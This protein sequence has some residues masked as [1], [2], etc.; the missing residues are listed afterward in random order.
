[1]R[2]LPLYA[3]QGW[4]DQNT[5]ARPAFYAGN[6]APL[7]FKYNVND[8]FLDYSTGDLHQKTDPATWTLLGT[9]PGSTAPSMAEVLAAVYPVGCLYTTTDGTN[10]A[11]TFGFGT[12]A[13]FG[14]GRVMVGYD[15][16]DT[17][18]DTAEETGG[19][20]TRTPSAHSGAAVAAHAAHTHAVTSNVAVGDHGAHTHDIASQLAT[21][22]LFTSNT[23][24]TGVSGRSGNPSATLTHSVTNNAVTSGDPSASLTHS[25][26]QPS[27]HSAISVV[28][29][30]I[31]VHVWK[32]T[33]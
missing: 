12:W 28:Q 23:G 1:M 18:F 5:N 3:P 33:A 9:L 29:P 27:D 31:V 20:K 17:D 21:P 13:A 2:K 4:L 14:A 10:P 8:Y 30:Y 6:G 11:T 26:T 32:R 16:G 22:D 15:S 24:G 7:S 19:A 25:V